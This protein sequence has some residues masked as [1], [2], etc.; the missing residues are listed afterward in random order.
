MD[1]L[2]TASTDITS[3]IGAL[4]LG[5][6]LESYGDG[7]LEAAGTMGPPPTVRET[8]HFKACGCAAP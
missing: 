7:V 4:E 5:D 6:H 1:N 3:M 2:S 8:I